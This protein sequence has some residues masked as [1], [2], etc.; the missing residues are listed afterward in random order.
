MQFPRQHRPCVP[1]WQSWISRRNALA[2]VDHHGPLFHSPFRTLGEYL[3]KAQVC[4]ESTL[5]PTLHFGVFHMCVNEHKVAS[6]GLNHRDSPAL[7]RERGGRL[8]P[9]RMDRQKAPCSQYFD[10]SS[11]GEYLVNS[12]TVRPSSRRA[13]LTGQ[14]Q[15]HGEVGRG[16][17]PPS[18]GLPPTPQGF[19][20][21][22]PHFSTPCGL[23]RSLSA[24]RRR[25]SCPR[26]AMQAT[27]QRCKR[28]ILP[29]Q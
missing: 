13:C 4:T 19:G 9:C 24:C 7:K 12:L 28:L 6:G 20:C 1:A 11:A 25:S 15:G 3:N 14:V 5:C 2:P 8:K 16:F 18:I 27:L 26:P 10:V 22:T 23:Q 21:S 17:A 29:S